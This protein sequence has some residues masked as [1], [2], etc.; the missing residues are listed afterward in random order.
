MDNES[1]LTSV[2]KQLNVPDE[3]TDFDIDILAAINTCISILHQ[4]GL[5]ST[6]LVVKDK[7]ATWDQLI[8]SP[9]FNIVKTYVFLKTKLIFDTPSSGIA[10]NSYK[11]T[12]SE[13]EWRIN[14]LC[15][16]YKNTVGGN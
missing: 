4:V 15:N 11:E 3:D 9:E 5:D 2:K 14:V 1:I 16:S 7:R 13:L 6:M 10:T 12:L 8:P